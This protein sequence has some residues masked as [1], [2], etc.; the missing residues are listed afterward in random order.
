MAQIREPYQYIM[1]ADLEYVKKDGSLKLLGKGSYGEVELARIVQR[2]EGEEQLSSEVVGKLVAVKRI[3]KLSMRN[4]K[5]R[6]TLMREV[7]IHSRVIHENI[8]RLYTSIEVEDKKNSL[9]Y[10]LLEYAEKGNLFFI[11]RH[12]K[13][14]S[15]AE[16]FFYFIQTCA[17][18]HFLHRQGLIHRDLKPENLLVDH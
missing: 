8:V 15:E 16:A 13:Q 10:L 11:I 7:D 2:P 3:D 6:A 12:K 9:I 17:G 18:L 14:M 5:I 4:Q 1:L